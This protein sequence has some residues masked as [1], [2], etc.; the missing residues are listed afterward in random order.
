MQCLVQEAHIYASGHVIK[1]LLDTCVKENSN[2]Y[3]CVYEEGYVL[4]AQA[5]SSRNQ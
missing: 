3:E 1:K 2:F 5:D 4:I